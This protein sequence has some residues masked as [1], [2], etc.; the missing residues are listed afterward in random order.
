MVLETVGLPGPRFTA[1]SSGALWA[2]PAFD[3]AD[4]TLIVISANVAFDLHV[5]DSAFKS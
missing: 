3:V 1:C 4:A 5:G 2:L